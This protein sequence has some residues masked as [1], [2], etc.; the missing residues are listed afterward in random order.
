MTNTCI[1]MNLVLLFKYMGYLFGIVRYIHEDRLK[2]KPFVTLPLTVIMFF[3]IFKTLTNLTISHILFL[4]KRS[5]G[6]QPL[7]MTVFLRN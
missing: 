2:Q 6:K 1:T 3:A 7:G 5:I 4:L